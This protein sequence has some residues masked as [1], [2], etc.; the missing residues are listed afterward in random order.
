MIASISASA[1]SLAAPIDE[2]LTIQP[3]QV[4]D[5]T[6]SNCAIP[7]LDTLQNVLSTVWAQAGIAPVLLPPEQQVPVNL[8]GSG[9]M[10]VGLT[11]GVNNN[12]VPPDGF[13]LLTRTEGNGQSPNPNT[14]NLYIVDTL[15]QP[16]LTVRGVSFINGNGITIGSDAVLDT[17]AHELGHVFGLDHTTP[18]N[19]PPDPHNLM[20]GSPQGTR[21]VPTSIDQIGPGG[22]DQLTQPQIDR[23]RQPLF[24]VGLGRVTST[25]LSNESCP[26]DDTCFNVSFQVDPNVSETLNSIVF[27]Y[28][29][30]DENSPTDF[31][32]LNTVGVNPSDVTETFAVTDNT[33]TLTVRFAPNSF[34][35]GDSIDFGTSF[36]G[37][38]EGPSLFEEITRPSNPISIIF[39]F[40]D[41]FASQAGFDAVT[42]AD[43]GF[44]NFTFVGTP[45][46]YVPG[47]CPDDP[48]TGRPSCFF[49][50]PPTFGEHIDFDVPEPSALASLSLGLAG[51]WL[52]RRRQ[53]SVIDRTGFADQS[54]PRRRG[55]RY[56]S[57]NAEVCSG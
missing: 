17:A 36:A 13:R 26:F 40:R 21:T 41:G 55:N 19:N 42:G 56:H 14:I 11:T 18:D 10:Q 16:G 46:Y 3:I 48:I 29:Q 9:S 20:T 4:C 22:L 31:E 23:A 32:L 7:D 27:K 57:N 33:T 43:S 52:M 37:L 50:P 44:G 54:E 5:P 1:A 12:I 45:S 28:R 51:F 30:N 6:I 39:N 38:I 53:S 2:A 47:T 25:P 35:Q 8:G 24:T 34:G 49:E 15:N